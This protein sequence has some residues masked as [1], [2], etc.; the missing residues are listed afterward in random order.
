MTNALDKTQKANV[1][2]PKEKQEVFV[3]K[4]AQRVSEMADMGQ[5][6]LPHNYSAENALQA[7]FFKL[8]EIDFKTKVA[9]IDKVSIE[10]VAFALQDMA[11]QGLSVAKN[12]GYFIPYGDKLQF[13][14]S[15]HGTKA[16]IKRLNGVKDIWAE[17]VWQGEELEIE[18]V[19]GKKVLKNHKVNW[20]A[21]SGK[22]EDILGAYAIIENEEG[23][24]YLEIMTMAEI[25]VAWS[26]SSNKSV[27]NK[28]PQEMAKRT[29]INRAAKHFINT[30]DDSDVLIDAIN[31]TTA[32]EYEDER[33]IK[34][35]TQSVKE[36]IK[37][38][39]NQELLDFEDAAEVVENKSV[40]PETGEI[41]SPQQDDVITIED[42][43]N[44]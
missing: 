5:I 3:T 31:R 29:V 37:R 15:Y 44:F 38:E 6:D 33:P 36:E 11:V 18:V 41:H 23:E 21:Q 12:Q 24:Q 20:M 42:D 26:T 1:L 4:V 32:N 19:R 2:T 40:D 16:I 39:A 17:V 13:Q 35:V 30:S 34:D 8:T 43:L 27:Q 25:E 10:S 9:L 28:Y 7:A 14:R 22:K